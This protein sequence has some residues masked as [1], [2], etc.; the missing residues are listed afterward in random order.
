LLNIPFVQKYN[1]FKPFSK[2][3]EVTVVP[4]NG[5]CRAIRSLV[6]ELESLTALSRDRLKFKVRIDADN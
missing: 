4:L 6:A 5:R 2:A 1:H 3:I